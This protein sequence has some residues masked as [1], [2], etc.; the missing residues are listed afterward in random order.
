MG[1]AEQKS[2]RA[3]P[4]LPAFISA[5]EDAAPGAPEPTEWAEGFPERSSQWRHLHSHFG[6]RLTRRRHWLTSAFKDRHHRPR[7]LSH[8]CHCPREHSPWAARAILVRGSQSQSESKKE[9][10]GRRAVRKS[11]VWAHEIASS[12]MMVLRSEATGE[13]CSERRQVPGFRERG[14]SVGVCGPCRKG[15]HDPF[16]R[17]QSCLTV[18]GRRAGDPAGGP[19]WAS[20]KRI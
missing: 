13:S 17:G 4:R 18:T 9:R 12:R 10:K 8:G 7:W 11:G 3:R 19:R 16:P 6:R 15:G 1:T 20:L 2:H 14:G 5:E